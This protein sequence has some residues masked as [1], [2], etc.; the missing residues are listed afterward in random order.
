MNKGS[1]SRIHLASRAARVPPESQ[2]FEHI[3]RHTQDGINISE[4]D[5]RTKKRRLV[6]CNDRFVEM[7]GRSREELLQADDINGFAR[8][9]EEP[10]PNPWE[11]LE[12]GRAFR[13]ICSWVRPDDKEN[14]FD[15]TASPIRREG[16]T[17]LVLGI[18]R[19]ITAQRKGL[20]AVQDG[21]AHL[22]SIF[23]AAQNVGF[24]TTDLA[25]RDAT[26]TDFSP[27][28]EK[29]FGYTRDEIVGRPLAVLHRREDVKAFGPVTEQLR[30]GNPGMSI[31]TEL[32]RKSGETFPALLSTYPIFDSQGNMTSVLGVTIDISERKRAE[33][34][35]RESER[36]Y[37]RLVELSPDAVFVH[38]ENRIRLINAAG[39]KMLGPAEPEEIIGKKALDFVHPD[40]RDLVR[41]RI[42][43]V[44]AGQAVP[45]AE[46][47]LR[48]LDGSELIVESVSVSFHYDG[49]PAVQSILRDITKRRRTEEALREND[50]LI[51][52][53]FKCSTDG[54]NV[55]EKDAITG[56]RK[57]VLC[58]DRYVE[59]SGRTREELMRAED[60][61]DLIEAIDPLPERRMDEL[62][63]DGTTARGS[64]SWKRPDGKE[65][66]YEFTAS[67]LGY[68]GGKLLVMGIDRDTTEQRK[69]ENTL[70]EN[71]ELFQQILEHTN[72]GIHLVEYDPK[73]NTKRLLL[74]SERYVEMS[75]RS[76]D[77]LMRAEDLNVF[78]EQAYV[79]PPGFAR[80]M[81]RGLSCE[82]VASWKRPDDKPNRHYYTASPIGWRGE[83]ILIVGIDRDA[84]AQARMEEQMRQAAKMEAVGRLAGGIAHDFNNQL[85]VIK[86]Y[87]EIMRT[88]LAEDEPLRNQLEEIL[89]AANRAETLTSQLLT[90]G[91]KQLLHPEVLNLNTVLR[92][93][94]HPLHRVIGE[95]IRLSLVLGEGLGNVRIDPAQ[96]EQ[97]IM[98]MA[99]NAADAMPLGGSLTIQT[100]NVDLDE[101]HLRG[102]PTAAVGPHVMLAVCDTGEGMDSET[103]RR[104]FEPFFTTKEIGKGTGLGLS[105][106]Y[107][108]VEQSGGHIQLESSRGEGT[109]FRIYLP[110]VFESVRSTVE[111]VKVARSL[112]GTE[113]ILVV[114]D[115]APLRQLL[116][117]ALGRYG[118]TVLQA[119][120]TREAIPVGLHYEGPI[121]L[122]ISDVVMPRQSGPSL[123]KRL[124][125]AR[126]NMK[127][128]FI[129]GYA[130]KT[131]AQKK[132]VVGQ[133]L[134]T[135]PFSSAELVRRVRELL[136]EG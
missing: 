14:Y 128:L 27:G 10:S 64:A 79:P 81:Q 118:Y 102:D 96:I 105:T 72:D 87:C 60:L 101:S 11:E 53:L 56:A 92:E 89:N 35:L 104:I 108:F 95:D 132:H 83:N 82:G 48:R 135:K 133:N 47:K 134:L 124:C 21:E 100:A 43:R 115:E 9:I 94:S 113:T 7:S 32:L 54:I 58:N 50:N 18:D 39:A 46:V 73:N 111:P 114:E 110:R 45:F 12:Q 40:Y 42:R 122:L 19:D 63:R 61:N 119:S 66:A 129:S 127:V 76:R 28:A 69:V 90:F 36:R 17:L 67:L 77:E 106:V 97:A 84:T 91:R 20:L 121:D 86:G 33:L 123:A 136:D 23:E 55:V 103:A 13:A 29:I 25:G 112:R 75:G 38:A 44:H 22:R 131:I 6:L 74:C 99:I 126:P 59:M 70:R 80:R 8:C 98:N 37:R 15:F 5:L 49:K 2:L 88:D 41:D 26:I 3:L 85:T 4:L 116:V 78:L 93:L 109:T 34:A 24:V 107:G 120:G 1:H 52:E 57:L 65:N 16:D 31:E 62:L 117:T 68:R 30:R 51:R 130:E 125:K 71:N